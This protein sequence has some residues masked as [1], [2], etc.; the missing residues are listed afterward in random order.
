[1]K[2]DVPLWKISNLWKVKEEKLGGKNLTKSG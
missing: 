2:K 1:M